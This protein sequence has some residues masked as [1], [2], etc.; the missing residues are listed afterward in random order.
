M[1]CNSLV[2]IK[3]SMCKW[4]NNLYCILSNYLQKLQSLYQKLEKIAT[5]KTFNLSITKISLK[6]LMLPTSKIN[7]T[8]KVISLQHQI[9]QRHFNG[10]FKKLLYI[11]IHGQIHDDVPTLTVQRSFILSY[12]NIMGQ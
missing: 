7:R 4:S 11:Y 10:Q 2:N 3:V 12:I 8:L 9:Y 6:T 5:E 1:K